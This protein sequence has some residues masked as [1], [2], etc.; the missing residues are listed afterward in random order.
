M[1]SVVLFRA[2]DKED[3]FRKAFEAAD[4]GVVAVPVLSYEAV[5]KEELEAKLEDADQWAGLIITSPRASDLVADVMSQAG[6]SASD[7]KSKPIVCTG[8]RTAAGVAA[9]TDHLVIPEEKTAVGVGGEVVAIS[10]S[11]PWLFVCGN[12]RRDTLPQYLESASVSYEELIIYQTRPRKEV[13][14]KS[15]QPDWLV[16]FSPSGVEVIRENWPTQ[17]RK[18]RPQLAAIGPTTEEAMKGTG[19]QVAATAAAP[20]PNALVEALQRALTSF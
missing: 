20:E 12:L 3:P 13:D 11:R 10:D 18:K 17:W 6:A 4:W 7:W 19:W 16:F 8:K 1:P 15:L 9:F 5:N 2:S 14:L